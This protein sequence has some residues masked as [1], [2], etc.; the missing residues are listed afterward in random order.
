MS[1]EKSNLDAALEW[2]SQGF[3]VFPCVVGGKQPALDGGH[4]NAS[5]DPARIREMWSN[6]NYNI[7]CDPD[8]SG[9][10]SVVD[11]DPPRGENSLAELEME[12]G[13]LP[14][15]FTV[16]TPRGGLHRWFKGS[17]P[18]T[19]SKLGPKIDTRG[20]GMGYVLLPPSGVLGENLNPPLETGKVYSYVRPDTHRKIASLPQWVEERIAA[21]R[22]GSAASVELLDLAVNTE[23]ASSLLRAHVASGY[24]AIEGEGGDQRTYGV[25]AE[26][27][28]LGLS[29]ERAFELLRDEWNEFCL[30]P[31]DEEDLALKVRNASE[32][33]QND[34]GA[35]AVAPAA[36]I[37]SSSLL[38]EAAQGLQPS[39]PVKNISRFYPRDETEQETRPLPQWLI[40]GFLPAEGTAMMFGP[41]GSYKSFAALDIALSLAAGRACYGAEAQSPVP[42]VY[43]AGEGARGIEKLRRPAWRLA[44]QIEAPLPFYTVDT[45]PLVA[46]PEE[47]LQAIE[48]IEGRAIRPGL[49]VIDTTARSIAGM[50]ENDAKDAGL[51]VEAIDM[52]KRALKCTV[53]VVHHTGKDRDRGARGSNAFLGGI[54]TALEAEG[55]SVAKTLAL[56]VRRQKDAD[57]LEVPFLFQG[58]AVGGSLV[59]FEVDSATFGKATRT[60][61]A[62]EPAKIGRALRALG[63]IGES[64]EVSTQ[65]LSVHLTPPL[66][67]DTTE[68]QTRAQASTSRRL[69]QLARTTLAGY[70]LDRGRDFSWCLPIESETP[71]T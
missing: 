11:S 20:A 18:T 13:L 14:E 37:Y 41:P 15:T 26:I 38:A 64:R 6:P 43:F 69:R 39:P 27:L 54:D 12:H 71:S 66:V 58:K 4:K 9:Q 44:H 16:R 56:H 10:L 55:N 30:P 8:A 3:A 22:S 47:F 67:E 46:R 65:V 5:T 19:A 68:S 62:F 70:A 40:P 7:G 25:A 48:A 23:R 32:Y 53:L 51:F 52:L 50:N 61:D 33:A 29:P 28:N 35:W 49:V 42:T 36:E 1:L 21:D 24:V 45:V 60:E 2:A 57:A 17:L 34:P 31:W 59:F 63:A